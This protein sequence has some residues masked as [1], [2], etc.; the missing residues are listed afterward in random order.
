MNI[1][2]ITDNIFSLGGV[3]RV[4]SVLSNEL[5]KNYNVDILCVSNRNKIDRKIYNLNERINVEI[6]TNLFQK[7]FF[8]RVTGKLG[9]VLN[10][11]S[12]LF[13]NKKM[14]KILTEF[15]FPRSIREKFIM[16][17]NSKNYDVIIGVEGIFSILLAIIS[18]DL[19]AKTIGWQHNSFDAYF[20]TKKK[21]HWK[22][23]KLFEYYLKNL[24]EYVVL[25]DYDKKVIDKKF[26]INS[27][28]IYNP[29][30]FNS[31]KKSKLNN[32]TI[33]F[34]GRL[35]EEQKG[36][37][38]L[39]KAFNIVANKNKEWSLKIVGDGPDKKKLIKMINEYNLNDRVLLEEFTKNIKEHYL[40]ST[41]F[42][43]SSRWEG[44][45]LVLTE[46]MECGLPV[47]SFENSGPKE[48]INK[49]NING[50]L[51]KKEDFESLAEKIIN[52]IEN[53][54]DISKFSNESI[55]R[56]R[57]YSLDNIVKIWNEVL[58]KIGV[59]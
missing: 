45:G 11:N 24:N 41:I 34:V 42:V 7:N 40:N 23:D 20:K 36:L 48:I 18:N 26:K 50:I 44:F 58:D 29:L 35:V 16:K 31:S 49:N 55:K 14:I 46:A 33:L 5:S 38:L 54:N 8:E 59:Y 15:Y 22:Q 17:L 9:R 4:V 53:K 39:I 1:C 25:T 3:Q 57:D 28:R 43:S 37:D 19:S 6:D 32:K 56:A 10:E 47:V 51:V 2:F 27:K 13:N 12:N 30:S 52:L 21:Y